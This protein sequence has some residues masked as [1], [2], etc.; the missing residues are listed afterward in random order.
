[1]VLGVP[2]DMMHCGERVVPGVPEGALYILASDA[3][4]A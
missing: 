4:Q 2:M 1:M 3:R